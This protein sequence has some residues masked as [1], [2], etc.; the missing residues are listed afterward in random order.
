M[1]ELF[2]LAIHMYQATRLLRLPACRFYPSCSDYAKQSIELHGA[3]KG[4]VLAVHR[5]L[6]CH[7]FCQGGTDFPPSKANLSF[8]AEDAS[9]SAVE[10]SAATKPATQWITASSNL[11]HTLGSP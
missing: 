5:L 3:T 4:M 10:K 1:K 6:R 11:V 7:P 9:A 8:R 2:L